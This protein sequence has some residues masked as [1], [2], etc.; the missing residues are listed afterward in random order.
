[1]YKMDEDE[2]NGNMKHL[3]RTRQDDRKVC[4]DER[5]SERLAEGEKKD[6]KTVYF[7]SYL[8]RI[9]LDIF[10]YFHHF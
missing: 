1:M 4:L 10:I 9:F 2:M 6:I 5:E 8:Q 7:F 3:Q